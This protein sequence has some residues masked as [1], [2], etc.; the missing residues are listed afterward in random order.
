MSAGIAPDAPDD[1]D[2]AV[3][4]AAVV[5]DPVALVPDEPDVTG[6]ADDLLD[7]PH[8]APMSATTA[9]PVP[10]HVDLLQRPVIETLL[11]SD[12][13]RS[14]GHLIPSSSKP[15]R[16]L[17]ADGEDDGCKREHQSCSDRGPVEVALGD[18]GSCGRRSEPPS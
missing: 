9:K 16:L 17:Q 18:R 7:P 8:A 3:F 12:R 6:G 2:A 1:P 5:A 15:R 14:G 13:R 10:T 11:A 4:G